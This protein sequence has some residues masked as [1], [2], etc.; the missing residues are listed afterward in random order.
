MNFYSRCFLM[1]FMTVCCYKSVIGG[2]RLF[3]RWLVTLFLVL[4]ATFAVAQSPVEIHDRLLSPETP[5]Q[6]VALTL[7]VCTG[8]YDADLVEFLIR[9]KIPATLFVTK[10]WLQANPAGVA[11]IKAH[12][13]LFDVEDHGENHIPAVIGHGRTVYGI[14]GSPD[15]VHLRKEVT[16]GAKAIEQYIGVAPHWYRGTTAKYDAQA[17]D[18][19]RRL[20]YGIAGFSVNADQGATLRQQAI[21]SRLRN[22]QAGDI[23]IAHMNKPASETA[24]GLSAGLVELL[25]RGG[26]LCA[27]RPGLGAPGALTTA[28]CC[29]RSSQ[30]RGCWGY[31][32]CF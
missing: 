27:P 19:I 16:E 2:A 23:I 20:G 32:G 10:K 12:L 15:V 24:E 14:S 6:T 31:R 18:E 3:Y 11:V 9:N 21:E 28:K 4:R 22:V 26:H 5:N 17:A 1:L 8:R 13:D 29:K 25:K 7:V 30:D